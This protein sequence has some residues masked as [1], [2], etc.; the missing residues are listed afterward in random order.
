MFKAVI[1]LVLCGLCCSGCV[2]INSSK[3]SIK[4]YKTT[5]FGL[6]LSPGQYIHVRI[7]LVRHFYQEIPIYTN[8]IYYPNYNSSVDSDVSWNT[9]NV[10]E[11]FWVGNTNIIK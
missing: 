9:S 5:V 11:R 8:Q 1:L 4:A 6:D 10:K 2:S 3:R 7:G